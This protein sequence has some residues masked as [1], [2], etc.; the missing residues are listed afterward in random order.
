MTLD[1][2]MALPRPLAFVLPGGGAL[3]AYQVGVLRALAEAGV[4]PDMLVGVSAG[5]VNAALAAWNPGV[6]GSARIESLWRSIKRRDLLRVEPGRVALAF[7]G[8][9]S[10]FLDNRY[11]EVFLR[12]TFGFRLL[13]DA[14]VRV[15]V[16]A[17]NL[18]NG[19]AV[20][21]TAGDAASAIMASSAFP[22]V[23]P[24]VER[25]GLLLID[26]GV[27]ADMPLDLTLELGAASALV[28]SVPPLAEGPPPMRAI[29]LLFR[30]STFGVEAHDR[31]TLLRPPEGLAVLE[32]LAPPSSVTTFAVGHAGAI[33]DESYANAVSWLKPAG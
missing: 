21:L 32:V 33:I 7:T 11:G 14:P 17:T 10:S 30:A 20:A 1:R 31:T 4:H 28:L 25:D 9:R 16:I 29:D 23:Y 18:F 26:G 5:A 3:G 22:G 12:R 8:R 6:A 13:Q 2:V 24:P 15:V 27:V 19:R